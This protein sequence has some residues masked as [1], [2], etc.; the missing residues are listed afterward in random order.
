MTKLESGRGFLTFEGPLWL[1]TTDKMP[2]TQGPSQFEMTDKMPE[3]QGFVDIIP[4]SRG[5]GALFSN[6][7]VSAPLKKPTLPSYSSGARSRF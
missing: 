2:E 7:K 3:T 1:E 4:L 5:S 6:L